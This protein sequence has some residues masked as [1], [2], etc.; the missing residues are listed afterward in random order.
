MN[1]SLLLVLEEHTRFSSHKASDD[2]QLITANNR[3][4]STSH[5]WRNDSFM[6]EPLDSLDNRNSRRS[7]AAPSVKRTSVSG[8][9][10]ALPIGSGPE[11]SIVFKMSAARYLSDGGDR[12]RLAALSRLAHHIEVKADLATP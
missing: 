4:M 10:R 3:L 7:R 6:V 1:M 2:E 5:G 12:A 8:V 9:H 11:E